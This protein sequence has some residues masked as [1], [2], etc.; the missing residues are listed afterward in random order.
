MLCLAFLPAGQAGAAQL[1]RRCATEV[2]NQLEA[3]DLNSFFAAMANDL[4][5]QSC[6][7]AGK[8]ADADDATRG[9]LVTDFVDLQD[10]SAGR[11]GK[12]MGEVMRAAISGPNRCARVYQVEFS[13]NF[14]LTDTGLVSLSRNIEDL[15]PALRPV[16]EAVVGTY[17]SWPTKMLFV[18]RRIDLM[19]GRI[20]QSSSREVKF[21]CRGG[22]LLPKKDESHD[23][24]TGP[25]SIFR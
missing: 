19:T 7:V 24:N 22:R 21:E 11:P 2:M 17:T 16:K 13:K 6:E 8:S 9:Y 10:F 5:V 1:D 14:K 12:V 4:K 3:M 15:D 18:V 25:L 23:G 20:V